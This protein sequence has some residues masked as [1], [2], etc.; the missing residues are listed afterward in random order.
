MVTLALPVAFYN[1][2]MFFLGLPMWSIVVAAP[3]F[4]RDRGTADISVGPAGGR[5]RALYLA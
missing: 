1:F 5:V 4:S 2:A 3:C